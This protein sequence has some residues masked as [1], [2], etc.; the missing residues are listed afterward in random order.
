MT[1][2]LF[3]THYTNKSRRL[4]MM[5]QVPITHRLMFEHHVANI[6]HIPLDFVTA[7]C[8]S[9]MYAVTK[10]SIQCE[11]RQANHLWTLCTCALNVR[12]NWK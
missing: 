9:R 4:T 8:A 6:A 1:K 12:W 5:Y 2:V 7:S 3:A 11:V 10:C